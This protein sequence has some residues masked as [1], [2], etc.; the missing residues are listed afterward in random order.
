MAL[1]DP[2]PA[3]RA[4]SPQASPADMFL[5]DDFHHNGA[6]RLSY[7]FEYAT[8]MK[9][10]KGQDRFV[11]D[12][13]DTYDWYLKLGPLSNAD[14]KHLKGKIPTW[15]NFIAHHSCDDFWKKQ[16]IIPYLTKPLTVPTLNVAGW[17]D[18]EDFYGPFAIYQALEKQDRPNKNF[19]VVGPWSHGGWNRKDGKM[20][21]KID[22]GS[23]TSAYFRERIQAPF[24]RCHLKDRC[25]AKQPEAITFDAGAREWRTHNAWPP[26]ERV[27]RRSLYFGPNG[28]LS[29]NAP[30]SGASMS[31][32]TG[33]T[34][35]TGGPNDF[36][37]F[38]SDPAKPVHGADAEHM[39]SSHRSQPA[40][41]RA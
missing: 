3:L 37:E 10:S 2:H 32:A 40:D 8:M 9:T 28:R 4:S 23:N 39:V 13:Y 6:F 33:G 29:W 36:D 41:I 21:G 27:S 22:L 16:T 30:A 35:A 1:L 11:F 38:I 12:T 31:S 24:F 5:G 19:L 17:W 20:L 34:G 7:G 15:N 18:Q 14:G 25:D 26:T